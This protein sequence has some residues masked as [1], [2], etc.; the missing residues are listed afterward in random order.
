LGSFFWQLNGADVIVFTDDI[1]LKS[2]KLREKVCSGV[3]NLGVLLDCEANQKA[4]T[5]KPS[6]INQSASKVQ[7]WVVPND[8]EAVIR[9][10][11]LGLIEN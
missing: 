1:G 2:W 9:D 11:I 4:P 7:L 3:E 10:E 8:E 6:R 5:D